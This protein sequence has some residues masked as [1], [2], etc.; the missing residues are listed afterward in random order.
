MEA[1]QEFLEEIGQLDDVYIVSVENALA[2]I[3]N[4]VRVQDARN[5]EAFSC[6]DRGRERLCDKFNVC[7]Y[8]NIS[9][10]PNSPDHQGDR[11]FQTCG[12]CPPLYP[13][14]GN[15]TGSSDGPAGP[16]APLPPGGVGEEGPVA[17][18]GRAKPGLTL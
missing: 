5:A 17:P 2:W 4:P 7:R 13:W 14:L 12:A 6:P 9:F 16:D 3:R 1:M 15:P 10:Y 8:H 18:G 11:V